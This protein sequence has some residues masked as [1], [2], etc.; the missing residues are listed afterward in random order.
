VVSDRFGTYAFFMSSGLDFRMDDMDKKRNASDGYGG[1]V[2]NSPFYPGSATLRRAIRENSVSFPSQVSPL[3]K[4]SAND[5][6]W[7]AVVLYF[8]RGWSSGEICVRFHVPRHRI[9]QILKDWS[10]K[11]LALGCMEVI[12][13]KAF[14]ACCLASAARNANA[15]TGLI[16]AESRRRA[17]LFS[18]PQL[19]RRRKEFRMPSPKG[20][21]YL[22]ARVF[23]A[24]V[25]AVATAWAADVPAFRAD[26]ALVLVPV[27]VV[28]RRGA[29]IDGLARDAFTLTENGVRQTIGSFSEEDA[30]VSLGVVFDLS[31]SMRNVLGPA[32]ESLRALL[33]DADPADEA[34]L[35]T[36][37]THPRIYSRFTEDFDDILG[38]IALENASGSTALFDTVW[39]SLRELHSGVH[40]RK[41]LLVISD[42]M[43]NHSR[44]SRAALLER[45]EE[46]DVQVYTIAVTGS[47]APSTKAIALTE[48]RRGLLFLDELARRTG[49]IGFVVNGR[50]DIAR[51]AAS[52]GRALRNQYVIG[53]APQGD[54]RSGQWR[55]IG[56]KVAVPEMRAYARA[57]YHRD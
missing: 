21:F 36:V 19:S 22:V 39:E 13:P 57:G 12:D 29:V 28:D 45:A 2:L 53:Y 34:F 33:S 15:G 38:R 9:R 18:A 23:A 51:A 14:Q 8:V 3:L 37:S 6:Q 35:S 16:L 32:K 1:P 27:T 30:P 10:V 11:A 20:K 55:R 48:E 24:T 52:I 4:S 25:F 44:H 50:T 40:A 41:A 49:G 26:S 46:S 5:M 42:G 17:A 47:A 31:G 54:V 56:V 43:D 7:R